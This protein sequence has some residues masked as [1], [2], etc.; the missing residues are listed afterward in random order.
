MTTDL[1]IL[2]TAGTIVF[3]FLILHLVFLRNRS[4]ANVFKNLASAYLAA[5]LG[6]LLPNLSVLSGKLMTGIGISIFAF[7]ILISIVFSGMTILVYI[8]VLF[9]IMLTSVRMRILG[10]IYQSGKKGL[11][12]R[13]ILT[14]YNTEKLLTV[15]LERFVA[16]GEI[17][18]RSGFFL[19][20]KKF[21]PYS[22]PDLVI[23][24]VWKMYGGLEI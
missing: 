16:S 14:R 23:R 17:I 19:R 15:R 1:F 6:A 18:Y 9:G 7:G 3:L 13:E 8:L 10:E 4:T 21:T 20:Q 11:S 12:Q 22:L 24:L 2:L 5:V